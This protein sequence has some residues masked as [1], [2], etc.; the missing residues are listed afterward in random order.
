MGKPEE[1]KSHFKRAMLYGGR[2]SAVILD[3]YAEVL[4]ALGEYDKAMVYWREALRKNGGEI[5]D[6]E[7]RVRLRQQQMKTKRDR[8]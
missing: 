8:K 6:L 3:H 7:D 5:P 4:F 1:A 2:D